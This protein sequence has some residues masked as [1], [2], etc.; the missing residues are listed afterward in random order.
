LT[1]REG[2]GMVAWRGAGATGTER[3]EPRPM[4]ELTLA[5]YLT[6]CAVAFMAGCAVTV[7]LGLMRH[8]RR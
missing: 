5:Q 7:G 2:S 6:V 1:D 8:D 4:I 3:E